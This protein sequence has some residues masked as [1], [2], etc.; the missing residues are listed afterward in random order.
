MVFANEKRGS[1]LLEVLLSVVILSV[2]LTAMIQ[3]MTSALRAGRYSTDYM[4]ALTAMEDNMFDLLEEGFVGTGSSQR[5]A[6]DPYGDYRYFLEA[7]P[8]DDTSPGGI[9][10][11]SAGILWKR[12]KRQNRIVFK[13]YGFAEPAVS[14]GSD[15][16]AQE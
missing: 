11:V 8:L 12:G 1:I 3:S 6:G 15:R 10:E 2:G 13:T 9:Q 7:E 5:Q 16:K 4:I 14:L